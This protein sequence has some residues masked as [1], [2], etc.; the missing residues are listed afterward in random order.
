MTSLRQMANTSHQHQRKTVSLLVIKKG[1][2]FILSLIC[3]KGNTMDAAKRTKL[4]KVVE[5]I[6]NNA[7]DFKIVHVDKTNW[8]NVIT[9]R[10]QTI[11]DLLF[12]G[13]ENSSTRIKCINSLEYDGEFFRIH[14]FLSHVNLSGDIETDE[15][16]L[17]NGNVLLINYQEFCNPVTGYHICRINGVDKIIKGQM[18]GQNSD[19]AFQTVNN[20]V[21]E[22]YD[23]VIR[24]NSNRSIKNNAAI[25]ELLTRSNANNGEEYLLNKLKDIKI[26]NRN[27]IAVKLKLNNSYTI[28][29]KEELDKNKDNIS[30]YYPIITHEECENLI[31]KIPKSEYDFTVIGLGSA[32]TG[33]LDQAARSTYFKNYLLIDFDKIEEKNLRNQWYTRNEAG[34]YKA[35]RSKERIQN[36]KSASVYAYVDKFQN[37]NL[38]TRKSKYVVSGF[39]NLECRLELLNECLT[40][41]ETRYLIDLRYLDYSCSIYFIDLQDEIQVKYYRN[42]LSADMES[43]E[44]KTKYITTK[45]ELMEYWEYKNYFFKGCMNARDELFKE[46]ESCNACCNE[47]SCRDYLWGL[48]QKARPKIEIKEESSCVRENFIDIYKYASSF[49]FSAI[50]EIEKGNDKPFT[51]IEAQTDV[52][53]TSVVIKV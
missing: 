33:I 45:E 23:Y 15:L 6:N 29:K 20:V 28:I 27:E 11:E 41:F 1:G 13:Y 9:K 4:L 18:M 34:G 53:P 37:V 2:E 5:E 50:R 16:E 30:T 38:N 51:H 19:S 42:L 8:T 12:M 7:G 52:I 48:F 32:G 26:P 47:T 14:E 22:G 46:C 35:I 43:F 49:V 36:I 40:S 44:A 25:I 21:N 39:D 31:S 24:D 17:D 3:K 10:R